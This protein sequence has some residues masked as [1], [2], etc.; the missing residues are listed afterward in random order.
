MPPTDWQAPAP[1]GYLYSVPHAGIAW[2]YL[3]R[4]ESYQSDYRR[5]SRLLPGDPRQPDYVRRWG[6]RFR[7]RPGYRV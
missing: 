2:D 1:Y 5:W 3:R 7:D 4:N 6:L